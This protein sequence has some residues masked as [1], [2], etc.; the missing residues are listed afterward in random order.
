MDTKEDEYLKKV[1]TEGKKHAMDVVEAVFT[2]ILMYLVFT[3]NNSYVAIGK[4][5]IPLDVLIFLPLIISDTVYY[6]FKYKK[7]KR[8]RDLFLGLFLGAVLIGL[9][10]QIII[11]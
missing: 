5:E 6:L 3:D 10:F 9:V 8:K 1:E 11:R 7:I 2:M 4:K